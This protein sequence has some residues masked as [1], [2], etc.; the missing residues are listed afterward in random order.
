MQAKTV[1]WRF[2][3]KGKL[4]DMI[5]YVAVFLNINHVIKVDKAEMCHNADFGSG[6]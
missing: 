1:L 3:E 2:L 6:L 4:E 5:I